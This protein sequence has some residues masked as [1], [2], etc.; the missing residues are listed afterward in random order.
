MP[1]FGATVLLAV[2]SA[3]DCSP[4]DNRQ[5]ELKR[6][7]GPDHPLKER[8]RNYIPGSLAAGSPIDAG[9]SG[10]AVISLFFG[11][12]TMES[13]SLD[14]DLSPP[15]RAV[16]SGNP[17]AAAFARL[18]RICNGSS[19]RIRCRFA[20]RKNRKP[21]ISATN[22]KNFLQIS[23]RC[24]KNDA[25]GEDFRGFGWLPF[26]AWQRGSN[27]LSRLGSTPADRPE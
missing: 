27:C 22:G 24:S 4:T 9:T 17:A 14:P 7:H 8:T 26:R 23:C 16:D 5:F 21:R 25:I 15:R 11:L 3:K 6:L 2:R 18:Q 13:Q 10:A 20:A 12:R 19:L 1:G